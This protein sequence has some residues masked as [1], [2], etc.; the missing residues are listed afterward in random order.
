MR[1][2]FSFSHQQK[3]LPYTQIV[4]QERIKA[5]LAFQSK[6][7]RIT[8]S[9]LVFLERIIF[10][11]IIEKLNLFITWHA[12][13]C[14]APIN[15]CLVGLFLETETNYHKSHDFRFKA[16]LHL[17]ISATQKQQQLLLPVILKNGNSRRLKPLPKL[18]LRILLHFWISQTELGS[19][20]RISTSVPISWER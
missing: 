10:L 6:L 16:R 5:S 20:G 14:C 12:I 13:L 1:S 8:E 4:Q 11:A 7:F 15:N 19:S 18:L 2:T 9:V 3:L 17:K